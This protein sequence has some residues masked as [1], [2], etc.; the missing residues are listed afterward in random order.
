MG[1]QKG[2]KKNTHTQRTSRT[3]L[4]DVGIILCWE[5]STPL[6]LSRVDYAPLWRPEELPGEPPS[7]AWK[8]V[9]YYDAFRGQRIST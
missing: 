9:K 6:L 4:N 5:L 7:L 3:D 2:R 1:L 8:V